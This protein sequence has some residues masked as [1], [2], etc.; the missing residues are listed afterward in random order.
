[1]DQAIYAA[2]SPT[3]YIYGVSKGRVFQFDAV[4]GALVQSKQFYSPIRYPS[5]IAYHAGLE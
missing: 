2:T 5:S 1:M 3:P 4:K